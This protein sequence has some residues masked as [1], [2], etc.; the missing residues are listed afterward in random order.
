MFLAK[1]NKSPF[2]QI[3][4][5]VDGKRTK[6]STK[7]KT[8]AEA[9]KILRQFEKP[10]VRKTVSKI[11]LLSEFRDE[12][13]SYSRQSKT[14][15]YLKSIGLS[16]R[17]LILFTG[18]VPLNHLSTRI[19]DQFITSTYSRAKGAAGLYYRTLK[20]AFSKAVVWEYIPENP[21]KKIK[22]PKQVKSLPIF[23]N[24]EELQII[25][26]NTKHEFLK[27]IFITAFYTGM[28]LGELLNMNWL[29][30][31][32]NQSLI[33]VKNSNGFTTK[34]KEERVIP[35]HQK[36]KEVLV[37]R[38]STNGKSN[39]V[40]YRYEGLKFNEDFVSKQF[41]K[42]VRLTGL[43]DEIHF[44]SLRHSFASAL[45]QSGASLY[46][47]KDLL[48]HQDFQTTQIYCHLQKENLSQAVNLL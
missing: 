45:V 10:T 34:S 3:V 32:F 29:W 11:I 1:D 31:D 46:I 6:K 15:S 38:Y 7:K 18:N 43:N 19:L 48:G 42:A 13:I 26:N 44:H 21:F 36:V 33:T 17:Q 47:V 28:R 37:R 9:L 5:F 27:D 12:Y 2:Y 35:F 30:I 8:K 40:F 20:A 22:A 16:F 25:I 23:I 41:K 4:Y 14:K 39:F 24:K